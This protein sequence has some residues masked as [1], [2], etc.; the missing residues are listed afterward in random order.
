MTAVLVPDGAQTAALQSWDIAAQ[1]IDRR[2]GDVVHWVNVKGPG[3]RKHLVATI[4]SV[5]DVQTISV[6]LCKFHLPNARMLRDPGYLYRWTL[7]LLVER[8]SW[9][10]QSRGSQVGMTFS[11]VQGLDPETLHRYLELLRAEH[12]THIEWGALK[13]PA[14]IDTPA[15]R[16]MLQLADTAS[17][18]VFAAFEPDDYGFTEQGFLEMLR[19]VIWRRP[20]RP[21]WK[22][23]LKYGP[24]P[25]PADCAPE[26]PW[27][28][29]FCDRT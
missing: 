2:P 23:G 4:A 5:W 17:G 3:Q 13:L 15:N 16:R 19:P 26:H 25:T 21:L 11:Q 22:E 24:W 14:R 28:Q 7:R 10:G 18:A 8:L 20:S 12:E 27:F 9:F 1:Q 6:V 29:G